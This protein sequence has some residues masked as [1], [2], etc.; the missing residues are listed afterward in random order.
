MGVDAYP[1]VNLEAS[2]IDDDTGELG[3]KVRITVRPSTA[4]QATKRALCAGWL[5][6]LKRNIVEMSTD[7]RTRWK[8]SVIN[9]HERI[10]HP[11]ELLK[12]T[13]SNDFGFTT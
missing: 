5:L 8:I 1:L 3:Q 9:Q 12:P 13:D 11:S 2:S 4:Y 10:T 7:G 6:V